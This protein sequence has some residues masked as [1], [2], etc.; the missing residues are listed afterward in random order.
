ME[1]LAGS[2][3]IE[4]ELLNGCTCGEA[5]H[6]LGKSPGNR[7]PPEIWD[8]E[9]EAFTSLV[10]IFVDYTQVEDFDQ[11]L[12]NGSELLMIVPLAGG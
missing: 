5:I 7:L 6:Q 1:Q 12:H 10:S 9:Q 11:P 2:S 3:S 4:V 8:A